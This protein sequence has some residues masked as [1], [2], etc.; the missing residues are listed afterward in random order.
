MA[1]ISLGVAMCRPHAAREDTVLSPKL[2]H[3][4]SGHEL[5]AIGEEMEKREHQHFGED[6][7]RRPSPR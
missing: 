1:A 6:G 4:I 3:T 2:C 5:D 7:S